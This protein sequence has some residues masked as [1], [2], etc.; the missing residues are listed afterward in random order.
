[1][2][3]AALLLAV[4]ATACAF[5]VASARSAAADE[6][7]A[8][9]QKPAETAASTLVPLFDCYRTN[10]AWGYT[11]SGRLI[12]VDG[13]LWTYG[14]RGK[15]WLPQ[16]MEDAGVRFYP[17][18]DLLEKYTDAQQSGSVDAAT[19]AEKSKLIADAAAG[20]MVPEDSG[21]RDAGYSGC[22]AYVRNAAHRGYRDVDLGSDGGVNDTRVKNDSEAAQQL[23]A[24]L[25]SIKVA[26]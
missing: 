26:L 24:W 11:L 20:Q 6:P 15:A 8:P 4:F 21:V 7:P 9:A 1:M 5:R 14:R 18:A 13:R 16:A 25:R 10:S 23:L 19:L 12:D 22:H 3:R 17:A 2:L